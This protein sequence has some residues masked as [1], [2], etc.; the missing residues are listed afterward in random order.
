[1]KCTNPAPTVATVPL[2]LRLCEDSPPSL[3][4]HTEPAIKKGPMKPLAAGDHNHPHPPPLH[5]QISNRAINCP[6][7]PG[8]PSLPDVTNSG[9]NDYKFDPDHVHNCSQGAKSSK[10][11]EPSCVPQTR[12][13]PSKSRQRTP[14][15]YTW[16]QFKN[17]A[18]LKSQQ[19]T[20]PR[21]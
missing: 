19:S 14:P 15:P 10:C 8:R 12:D 2:P 18:N 16:T 5:T 20:V 9:R 21:N 6:S 13:V 11:T 7:A 17:F 1:M 4:H 3:P